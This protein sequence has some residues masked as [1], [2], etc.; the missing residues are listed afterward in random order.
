MRLIAILVGLLIVGYLVN[1]QLSPHNSSTEHK[2]GADHQEMVVP[3]VPQ[4]PADVKAF[5]TDINKFIH[6][7]AEAR[8]KEPE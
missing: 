3:D 5:E 7:S 2:P 6:D 4:S 8:N 1:K